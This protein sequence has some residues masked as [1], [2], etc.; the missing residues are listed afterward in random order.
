[1]STPRVAVIGCGR[2]GKNII[3]NLA[4]MGALQAVV[5]ADLDRARGQGEAHGVAAEQSLAELL[6][7]PGSID[8]VAIATPSETHADLALAALEADLD[9][10]VEKPMAT[11]VVDGERMLKL[12]ANRDRI[13]MVGHLLEYH[14]AILKLKELVD[15]GALGR[16]E[17]VY[18]N[19]LN[20]GRVRQE[21]NAL[22]SF[23]PHDVAVLLLLVGELPIQVTATGGSYLQP[24][25]ADVTVTNLLFD[26]GLRSHI[27]VSWLH[28]F[29]E[30]KLVVTGTKAMVVF[31]DV[32]SEDKLLLYDR[33]I[34]NIEGE[35][36]AHRVDGKP[37]EY[38]RIE[39]L[40]AELSHFL[41]C[42][43][44]RAKPRTDGWNGLRVLSV[45]Q[46][47]QRSI[48]VNGEP[49]VLRANLQEIIWA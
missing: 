16:I 40:R 34:V 24:N 36:V 46:A 1:M 37:I 8:A 2:W 32:V 38:D 26:G 45:L 25:I 14:G 4:E 5:D 27:F 29:K 44:S 35:M 12:A 22:W 28:P 49:I 7:R 11:R 33:N 6:S 17:Y 23:A 47:S 48:Q 3:R 42:M 20:M 18:S 19:R 9:V 30:Q 31:N 13:L 21:E 10:F 15:A 39:P 43:V 41:E